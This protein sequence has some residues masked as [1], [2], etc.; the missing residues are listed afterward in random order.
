MVSDIETFA[1]QIPVF[2]GDKTGEIVGTEADCSKG[3]DVTYGA[4][5]FF[6][7]LQ[8]G[9]VALDDAQ[10]GELPFAKFALSA[11]VPFVLAFI[12]AEFLVGPAVEFF[13]AAETV[14]FEFHSR[15]IRLGHSACTTEEFLFQNNNSFGRKEFFSPDDFV[16]SC[17]IILTSDRKKQAITESFVFIFALLS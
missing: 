13:P 14:S 12:A 10:G 1:Y 8:D 5:R 17:R 9:V 3:L 15:N 4:A 16:Y 2:V 7:V 11:V 6:E